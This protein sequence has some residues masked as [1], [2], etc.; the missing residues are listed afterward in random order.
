M[1]D[2]D[3]EPQVPAE[4]EEHSSP[5]ESGESGEDGGADS[6]DESSEGSDLDVMEEA[7]E[8]GRELHPRVITSSWH[9]QLAYAAKKG[10]CSWRSRIPQCQ[11]ERLRQAGWSGKCYLRLDGLVESFEEK[12][13][14]PTVGKHEKG[15]TIVA[16]A[17]PLFQERFLPL[18]IKSP[19]AISSWISYVKKVDRGVAA[20][21]AEVRSLDCPFKHGPERLK[22]LQQIFAEQQYGGGGKCEWGYKRVTHC[23]MTVGDIF[24]M[25][26][27]VY[28]SAF[29]GFWV[30]NLNG[31]SECVRV[32]DT[33][34]AML[35]EKASGS[36][37]VRPDLRE[38]LLASV[39]VAPEPVAP[40]PKKMMPPPYPLGPPRMI[41]DPPAI[42]DVQGGK[43][44]KEKGSGKGKSSNAIGNG[45]NQAEQ[46]HVVPEVPISLDVQGGKGVQEKGGGKGKGS[47]ATGNIANDAVVA[48]APLNL[49]VKGGKGEKEKGGGKGRA[50]GKGKKG[51]KDSAVKGN[52]DKGHAKGKAKGKGKKDSN[53]HGK[54][55]NAPEHQQMMPE[56]QSDVPG[57]KGEWEKGYGKGKAKGKGKKGSNGKGANNAGHQD[58]TDVKGGK[59]DRNK[60]HGK[61]K[62][63]GKGKK[64]SNGHGK[65]ANDAEHHHMTPEA[66]VNLDVSGGKG[67]REKGY[68]KGK[69]KGKGKKG[70]KDF[71]AKGD[72]DKG[73]GKGSP[74]G[75]GK[76]GGKD[77]H[78]K[79]G[80]DK[81]GWEKGYGKGNAKGK[82]KKGLEQNYM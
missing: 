10:E 82:G 41:I 58:F 20:T 81:G 51:G 67:E 71:Q 79:G 3:S 61:G 18:W 15:A 55:A 17:M 63:K 16:Y 66:Q 65:G 62:A 42:L 22:W 27:L 14:F 46:Q 24:I 2:T 70:G 57:G 21:H 11:M 5:S 52:W 76:K 56:A 73:Y 9:M 72:W 6:E 33:F 80:W 44:E 7:C 37:D 26:E 12:L 47:N 1:A 45:A 43:G 39:A 59:G 13:C 30:V 19:S 8:R 38:A 60:G 49:D 53:G 74:K 36:G 77:F 48:E 4:D 23:S 68:G 29:D 40:K 64:G 75:G 50:K 31:H 54:G 35:E 78:A 34:G 69:A 32:E 28:L 25:G